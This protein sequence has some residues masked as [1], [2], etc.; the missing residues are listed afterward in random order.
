MQDKLLFPS[1]VQEMT[2][3]SQPTIY[4][5]RR[6]NKFPSPIVLGERRIAYKASEIREWLDQRERVVS[7]PLPLKAKSSPSD[8]TA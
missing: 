4:R 8:E 2:H 6:K 7:S 1:E 5:L 3:L